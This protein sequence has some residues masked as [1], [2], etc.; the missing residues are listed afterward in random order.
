MHLNPYLN[1]NGQCEA[2]FKHYER[3]LGGKIQMMMTH[4]QSPMA[5]QVTPQWRDKIM[6]ICLAFNGNLLM[7]SDTPSQRY[8]EPKG[9]AINVTVDT[10]PEAERVFA[11]LS[12]GGK[13]SMPLAQ[14]FWTS[15]FGMLTDQFGIPW[16]VNCSQP[17]DAAATPGKNS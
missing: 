14:T 8:S 5:D 7:G 10:V 15:R 9:F 6:H 12:E 13:V 16:A 2:A 3:S 4:G 17:P 1:F 11:E